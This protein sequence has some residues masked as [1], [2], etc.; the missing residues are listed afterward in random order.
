M[1]VPANPFSDFSK[2]FGEMKLPGF[3]L[4][5][6]YEMQRKNVE[7]MTAAN[8]L[9][10]DSMRAVVE[11]QVQLAQQSTENAQA[12][13]RSMAE[14]GG[15]VDAEEQLERARA[16]VEKATADLRELMDMVTRS[17]SEIYDILNKRMM[18]AL[19]EM[20]AQ[21]TTR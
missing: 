21:F 1:P 15:T 10:L 4:A 16:A 3:D 13:L 8:R 20:K 7:A 2:L 12:A 17:Q 18:E 5:A 11:R 14:G 19:E 6:I 9:A